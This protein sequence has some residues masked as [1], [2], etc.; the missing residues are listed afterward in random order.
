VYRY[1]DRQLPYSDA[2]V[3]EIL[4]VGGAIKYVL[5]DG[6]EITDDWLFTNVVPKIRR[7]FQ[8]DN[9]LCRVLAL[10]LLFGCLDDDVKN[11][12]PDVIVE[13]VCIAYNALGL[14]VTQ[15]VE[16]VLLQVVTENENLVI[17]QKYLIGAGD[18]SGI[19]GTQFPAS[20]Q[21]GDTIVSELNYRTCTIEQRQ[22]QHALST[23]E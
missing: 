16:K 8:Q 12:I 20:L 13:R 18:A 23:Q 6:V 5:K 22:E 7:K 4:C 2:M 1:I 11:M 15:P 3:A 21:H 17:R 14:D 19:T 9:G 10:S